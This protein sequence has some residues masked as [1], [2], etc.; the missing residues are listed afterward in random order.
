MRKVMVA[1]TKNL[2]NIIRNHVSIFFCSNMVSSICVKTINN[3]IMVTLCKPQ[4]VKSF[5][6]DVC[7][8]KHGFLFFVR[9]IMVKHCF[10]AAKI[11]KIII[12][13]K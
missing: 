5:F 7:K 2:M 11:T 1:C 9:D 3:S 13:T 10:H 8:A 6:G 12:R 4:R